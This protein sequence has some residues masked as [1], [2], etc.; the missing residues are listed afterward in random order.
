MRLKIINRLNNRPFSIP[1]KRKI[2]V[3]ENQDEKVVIHSMVGDKEASWH[4]DRYK[5]TVVVSILSIITITGGILWLASG[6]GKD[7]NAASPYPTGELDFSEK[8]R[9]KTLQDVPYPSVK[10]S[11]KRLI[12]GAP[13]TVPSKVPTQ[14][15]TPSPTA[16]PAP[17]ATPV[18]TATSVPATPT[19]TQQTLPVTEL[20]I[21]DTKVGEGSAVK[22][23]DNIR[24]NYIGTLTNGTKFD[25]SY[26][27]GTP[28]ETQ[29][30]VGQVIEGWDKGIIGMKPGGK[31]KLTIPADMAY[32]S[33]AK[34]NIPA[35]S[36]LIFEVELVE[37]K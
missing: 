1:F 37:I 29:I 31:R 15:Q 10:N 28:F 19:P 21:E 18:P 20:K 17:T 26:D 33:T 14:T 30:G 35:N 25:S 6:G 9:G 11:D 8:Q 16:T 36:A 2:P 4:I 22:S 34:P 27:R 7:A 3:T 13:S 24:I 32:G 12:T 23:G 5:V